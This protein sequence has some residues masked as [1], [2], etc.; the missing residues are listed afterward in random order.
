MGEG[1]VRVKMDNQVKVTISTDASGAVEG[2][3]RFRDE[4]DKTEKHSGGITSGLN[5]QWVKVSA[6]V[7]AAAAAAYKAMQMIEEA[8]KARAVESSFRLIAE[9]A[10]VNSDAMIAS[11][12]K[13]TRHTIDSSDMMQKAVKLMLQGYNADQIVRFSEGAVT[14]ARYMGTTISEAYEIMA[15][16]IANKMPKALVRAG[17]VTREQ[18]E[19]VNKAVAAGADEMALYELAMANLE[20]KALKLKGT[21]DNATIAL[22]AFHAQVK[23]TKETIG[24]F[25][26][27]VLQKAYGALQW[28]AAGALTAAGTIPY[29]LAQMQYFQAWVKDKLGGTQEAANIRASADRTM[30]V[31]RDMFNAAEDLTGKA[32]QNISGVAEAEQSASQ[33]SIRA[34]EA[35]VK[36]QEAYLRKLADQKQANIDLERQARERERALD[37]YYKH[38][39]EILVAIGKAEED[40]I[41]EV[42][43]GTDATL[44]GLKKIASERIAFYDSIQGYEEQAYQLKLARIEEERQ[45]YI[46][47]YGDVAAANAKANQDNISALYY[48]IDS[49]QKWAKA[50]ISNFSNVIDAARDCYAEDS[51]EYRLLSDFKKGILVAEQA[52]E[53]AK[54]IK[55]LQGLATQTSAAVASAA[56]QNA[57]NASTA[58]TGAVA[59]VASSGSGDPYTGIARVAAMI[60]M[61][62]SVLAIAG[63]A[64]SPGSSSGTTAAA[65]PAMG[66][67]TVLGAAYGTASESIANSFKLMEDTYDMQYNRLTNI[68]NELRELNDN[69]TGLV[70]NIVMG[71]DSFDQS[72]FAATLG[73]AQTHWDQ[74]YNQIVGLFAGDP[75]R[76]FGLGKLDPLGEWVSQYMSGIVGSIMGGATKTMV[77]STGIEIGDTVIRAIMDGAQVSARKYTWYVTE[78]EGGWFGDDSRVYGMLY[79]KLDDNVTNMFT[80]VFQNLGETL[81]SLAIGLGTDVQAV[82]DYVFETKRLHLMGMDAEGISETLSEY[83]SEIGDTAAEELFGDVI[84][85]YQEVNEGL[86]ETAVRLVRDKEIV[87]TLL[88]LTNQAFPAAIGKTIELTEAIIKMA[89]GFDELTES[90]QTY[91]EAFF[92]EEEQQA[93]LKRQLT[94]AMG[95]YGYDLPGTRSGYRALVESLDLASTAGQAAYVALMKMSGAADDYYDYLEKAK[96]SIKESDYATRAEYL[97]AVNAPKFAEGGYFAGGYRIVGENGPE[98]EFTGSSRIFSNSETRKMLNT[99]TIIA[100]LEQ[101]R[102]EMGAAN[103]QIAA[104]TGKFAKMLNDWDGNGMPSDRGY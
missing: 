26:I 43:S 61:M 37:E 25:F 18:V 63:I 7:A 48:K 93:D 95:L 100:K 35:K 81:V 57:A 101:I 45:A 99:D 39:K 65:Q 15:D 55:F 78:T 52:M 3:R 16:A 68:Y 102:Q 28:L 54:Q 73:A 30:Q 80:K 21:Q 38:E 9:S 92:S 36:A 23:D 14:A 1:W 4:A 5:Q 64:F 103:F 22:Q 32:A 88:D 27:D 67:S 97:R 12:E 94:T 11:M 19:L 17:A 82:Y 33:T 66:N 75:A 20:V 31:A 86:L 41:K 58:V 87:T 6:G 70:R 96:S 49:E 24:G 2:F 53:I 74:N 8:A 85:K 47:M 79:D 89:G 77:G 51:R 71:S 42:Q 40:L 46:K 104:N 84:R 72:E 90:I 98:L 13:A 91:Y 59:S 10:R 60:A 69:I 34:A 62:A 56:A 83:F 29:L 76:F 50:A 44:N